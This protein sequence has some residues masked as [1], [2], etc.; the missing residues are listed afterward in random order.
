MFFLSRD[1]A[2]AGHGGRRCRPLPA[3]YLRR[4]NRTVGLFLPEDNPQRAEIPQVASAAELLKDYHP[5]ETAEVAEAF[6][7]SPDNIE[8]AR[9]HLEINGMKVAL[10]SKK[11]RGETVF[12]AMSLPVRRREVAVRP[13]RRGARWPAPMMM[14]GTTRYTREQLADE[15]AKLKVSGGVNGR[16]RQLPDHAAEHRRRDPSGRARAARSRRSRR[17][18][19][20]S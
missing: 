15:F 11:N 12:F 8:R 18:I 20:R 4:D 2:A 9:K 7:P 10:L 3:K 6:D 16:G 14:R 19:R 17:R 13:E 1:R 5:K